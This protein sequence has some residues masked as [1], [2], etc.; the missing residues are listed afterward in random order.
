MDDAE[1]LRQVGRLVR[2]ARQE[3]GL[4]QE[5]LAFEAELDRTFVNMIE[6]GEQNVSLIKLAAIA[7][8][9]GVELRA[10]IPSSRP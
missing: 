7:R 6:G 9:L 4:T 8:G 5:K 2:E 10:L 1:L 3:K